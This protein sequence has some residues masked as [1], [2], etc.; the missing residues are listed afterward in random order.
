MIR[1]THEVKREME[2]E[3]DEMEM[4][5]RNKKWKCETFKDRET[6]H[7]VSSLCWLQPSPESSP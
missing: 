4:V 5:M 1:K 6:S 2:M 7:H 3:R